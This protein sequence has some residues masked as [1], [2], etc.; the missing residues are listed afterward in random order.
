MT[1]TE[2]ATRAMSI[3]GIPEYVYERIRVRAAENGRSMEAEVR[4][5]IED[6]MFDPRSTEPEKLGSRI[7]ARFAELGG[8]ELE[9][10]PRTDPMRE[11]EFFE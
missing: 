5:L 7:H 2:P 3:R 10:E 9:I 6:A 1:E 8:V 11:V 4:Q